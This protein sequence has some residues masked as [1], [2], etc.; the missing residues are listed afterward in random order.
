MSQIPL[1][2]LTSSPNL[3]TRGPQHLEMSSS[4]ISTRG[5][6]ATSI[7]SGNSSSCVPALGTPGAVGS[8]PSPRKVPIPLERKVIRSGG[9]LDRESN[10]SEDMPIITLPSFV[11]RRS[12]NSIP[13]L[14]LGPPNLPVT[15]GGGSFPSTRR[16]FLLSQPSRPRTK[17]ASTMRPTVPSSET[18]L[19][20]N[21]P[22]PSS[23]VLDRRLRLPH[24]THSSSRRAGVR[25]E[26]ATTKLKS[27]AQAEAV[28][29]IRPRTP[30]N[31]N[32]LRLNAPPP[33]ENPNHTLSSLDDHDHLPI[34]DQHPPYKNRGTGVVFRGPPR[35]ARL[36]S[37]DETLWEPAELEGTPPA[38]SLNDATKPSPSNQSPALSFSDSPSSYSSSEER[39]DRV[40]SQAGSSTSTVPSISAFPPP[41]DFIPGPGGNAFPTVRSV[42]ASPPD[43]RQTLTSLPGADIPRSISTVNSRPILNRHLHP[44]LMGRDRVSVRSG[45]PSRISSSRR[46]S[47]MPLGPRQMPDRSSLQRR[48][49]PS[50]T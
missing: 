9:T 15:E 13:S 28:K 3:H 31:M 29:T 42:D 43:E 25:G 2:Y 19:G 10:P 36:Q 32:P 46:L 50:S 6:I 34:G 17:V 7:V 11:E 5:L 27:P 24:R 41:P 1:P 49:Q 8:D 4:M 30:E 26:P 37:P 12:R 18:H 23:L 21:F 44:E 20:H 33:L 40:V 48:T 16:S 35:L 47:R 39:R 38:I 22:G 14:I 45:V